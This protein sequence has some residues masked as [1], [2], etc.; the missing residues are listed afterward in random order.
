MRNSR[1]NDQRQINQGKS[2]DLANSDLPVIYI[3]ENS[4]LQ[5]NHV[6][7]ET[8]DGKMKH[9]KSTF[10]II[11]IKVENEYETPIDIELLP[12]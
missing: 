5:I 6:H 4:E 9:G 7:Y 11:L 8:T 1:P 2:T 10:F 12:N 3:T